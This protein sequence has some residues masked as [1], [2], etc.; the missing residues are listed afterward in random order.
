MSRSS[1][2]TQ[3]RFGRGEREFVLRI[4]M[5]LLKNRDD[6]EDVAQDAMLRAFR[7]R[8]GFRGDAKF[9]TWL[10]RVT[11]TSALMHLR[12]QRMEGRTR[13]DSLDECVTVPAPG[14]DPE[15]RA[16]AAAEVA[17]AR[18]HLAQIGPKVG[19]VLGMNAEGYTG[20]EI[21]TR[22]GIKATTARVRMRRGRAGLR[23]ELTL[24]G[25]SVTPPSARARAA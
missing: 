20:G 3:A 16:I 15:A 25:S 5:Q 13:V 18:R 4:A 1:S 23:A 24:D 19:K 14:P 7:G 21:G 11:V 17:R 9:L 8:D 12:K 22:L 10:H 2:D 6:A